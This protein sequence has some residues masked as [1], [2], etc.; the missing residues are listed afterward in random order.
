LSRAFHR[1]VPLRFAHCDPA[2][3]AFYPRLM[4]ICD[5]VVEDWTA[6]VIGA[7]RRVMHL[8]MGLALPTV[9]LRATFAAPCR[10]GDLLDISLDV[11]RVGQS[12]IG[13]SIRTAVEGEARFEI[14]YIQVL[15]DLAKGRSVPWPD[16]WR[17]R[18]LGA[19][20]KENAA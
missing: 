7:S 18:I 4:E 17:R 14:Q 10:L 2:G 20:E 3:I 12:S 19:A 9:D 5:G 15:S 11:T 6:E 8:E 1:R 16:E 13:L